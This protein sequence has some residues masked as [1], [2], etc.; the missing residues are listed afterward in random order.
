[1]VFNISSAH[2]PAVVGDGK[3]PGQYKNRHDLADKLTVGSPPPSKTLRDYVDDVVATQTK[4]AEGKQLYYGAI[5][6][7]GSGVRYFGDLC[8]VLKPNIDDDGTLILERNS[9][10]LARSPLI[11]RIKK[12]PAGWNAGAVTEV[13]QLTGSWPGDVPDIATCKILD[14]AT[15]SERRLTTGSIAAGIL[16]DEDYIEVVRTSSFGRPELEAVRVSAADAGAE[17]RIGD[18]VSRGP[19]AALTEMM[20]RHRRRECERLAST[21]GLPTRVVLGLGRMR[22]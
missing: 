11:E 9:Y 14:G 6:L 3:T 10:D 5:E 18:R 21:H 8:M 12:N 20:W 22:G 2:F 7:N 15:A 13:Q 16:V 4:G 17:A 19:A 1:M